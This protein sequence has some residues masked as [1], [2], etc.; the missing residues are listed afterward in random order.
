MADLLVYSHLA[1]VALAAGAAWMLAHHRRSRRASRERAARELGLKLDPVSGSMSGV[2]AGY[3]V[4]I[5]PSPNL[6]GK[7][8][9]RLRNKAQSDLTIAPRDASWFE[10]ER[11]LTGDATFDARY[12]VRGDFSFALAA[13]SR[14]VRDEFLSAVD[15]L[16]VSVG[17]L[18]L[19]VPESM[20]TAELLLRRLPELE[21]LASRLFVS[22][23]QMGRRLTRSARRDPVPQVR[24]R[25]LQAINALGESE[26]RRTALYVLEDRDEEVAVAAATLLG[27]EAANAAIYERLADAIERGSGGVFFDYLMVHADGRLRRKAV[28]VALHGSQ[29]ALITR[30][31][32]EL[33]RLEPES[34]LPRLIELASE[35]DPAVA[36]HATRLLARGGG[37][38]SEGALV[39][40]LQRDNY[41]VRRAAVDALRD[42][43]GVQAVEALHP[44][45]RELWVDPRLKVAARAAISAIQ[46]RLGPAD[47]G[48][49]SLSE[50]TERVES[51]ALSLTETEET[52]ELGEGPA[53]ARRGPP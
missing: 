34:Y 49:V 9:I 6:S 21:Q 17:T 18:E 3:A 51:G 28:S 22:R 16:H 33:E 20:A 42:S 35:G 15:P 29:P 4:S 39:R 12:A 47:A 46:S 25:C 44:L 1:F 45:A 24:I 10:G 19:V 43:G 8:V 52:D 31:L 37:E 13:L 26:A 2:R 23:E 27:T 41:E 32:E 7:T 11:F 40:L 14:E 50:Q 48:W 36:R 5:G 53:R 38:V 30:G